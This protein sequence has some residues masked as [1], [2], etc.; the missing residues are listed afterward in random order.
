MTIISGTL[1]PQDL[2]PAFLKEIKDRPEYIQLMQNIPAHVWEDEEADWWD[3]EAPYILEELF[4]VLDWYA[5]EGYYF[6]AHPGDGSDF[7]YWTEDNAQTL[8][9]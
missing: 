1:R 3:N 8:K 9:V 5:P 7:G 4:E 6:G 2:I